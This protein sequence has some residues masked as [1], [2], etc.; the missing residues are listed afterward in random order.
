MPVANIQ[1]L[2]DSYQERRR[3]GVVRLAY[4][5][6]KQL[7]FFFKRGKTLNAYLVTPERWELQ[8][9]EQSVSWALEAGDAYTQSAALS[10]FGALMTKLSVEARGETPIKVERAA[11]NEYF[12]N[13]QAQG[14]PAFLRLAWQNSAGAA[15]FAPNSTPHIQFLAR[16]VLID[17]PGSLKTFLDWEED[18]CMT[19]L[20]T[21]DLTAN[22][23]Q[24]YFL[25]LAFANIFESLMKR[26][27]VLTGRALIDSLA[28]MVSAFA[29]HQNLNVSVKARKLE[30]NEF[31]S[32]PQESAQ[33]YRFLLVEIFTH[34]S[35]VIGPRLHE[36]TVR[37]IVSRLSPFERQVIR[38]FDLLPKGYVNE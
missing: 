25:R 15:F 22:A 29:A 6:Q 24:E 8:T 34:F 23:W 32:T 33:K 16:D 2:L 37:E 21:P 20:F 31:F 4:A 36:I 13:I 5:L 18:S 11:L 19:Q 26:F 35:A 1:A 38:Q 28:R 7:F 3:T 10:T 17:E 27:E 14:Q 9:L 12:Q 30:D